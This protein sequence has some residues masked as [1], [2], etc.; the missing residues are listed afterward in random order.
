MT[1]PINID[2]TN[3][4][5]SNV[6]IDGQDVTQITIDGQD[7]LNAIPDSAI[8]RWKLDDVGTGTATDS[9]GGADG[10]VSGV[11]N[12]SSA[13]YQ[14]GSAGDGDGSNDEISTGTLGTFGSSLNTDFAIAFTIDNFDVSSTGLTSGYCMGVFNTGSSG[15]INFEVRLNEDSVGDIELKWRD[16]DNNTNAVQTNSGHVGDNNQHRVLINKVANTGTQLAEFYIADKNDASYTNVNASTLD[17]N[18]ANN[19]EDF[20]D[21]FGL[22]YSNGLG[23]H[24]DATLDE[25][26]IY[27]DSLTS[28]ERDNDLDLQPA[29]G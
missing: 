9:I 17:D 29:F 12:I 19:F 10:S 25:V 1:P 7:V 23:R 11:S 8:H 18:N 5:Y 3:E 2:G 16:A 27:D 20:T 26:I 6:T 13:D 14:G 28:S 15:N 24:T 22:F 4:N 21:N